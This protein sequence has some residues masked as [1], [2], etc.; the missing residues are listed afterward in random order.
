MALYY[1]GWALSRLQ[2]HS[3]ARESLVI[4]LAFAQRSDSD[5][6]SKKV[7]RR[8][9]KELYALPEPDDDDHADVSVVDLDEVV[10]SPGDPHR[11][12]WLLSLHEDA[13]RPWCVLPCPG[14]FAWLRCG[15]LAA[16][17]T[18]LACHLP[19]L[20]AMGLATRVCAEQIGAPR[21]PEEFCEDIVGQIARALA[22]GG[23]CLV[24]CSDGFAASGVVLACFL[25]VHGLDEPVGSG[26]PGKPQL[27]AGE[28]I[29]VLRAL[30]PGCLA[31]AED[32]EQ[33][34]AFAQAAWARHI[35]NAQRAFALQTTARS[36]PAQSA[37]AYPSDSA[38]SAPSSE[39][40]SKRP[41]PS[42]AR[43]VKQPGDGNCLFHSLAYGIGQTTAAT[44]RAAICSFMEKN[45]GLDIAGTPLAEWIQM[46]GGGN[47]A[48]YARKMAKGAEWGGA[49]EI[50]ACA[51]MSGINIH[52]YQRQG[53]G[54]ELTVP[55]D[56]GG[57]RTV[58]VLYVGGV[59]YDALVL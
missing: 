55:F 1:R 43:V 47:I 56:V 59:H 50:A 39:A 46:L 58:T 10:D 54:F 8:I 37:S 25:I 18:P 30:R 35:E 24:H 51:H 16:S 52:V 13:W 14:A 28:A 53:A 38:S 15:E 45:P 5:D 23:G 48:Q 42:S 27:T 41:A 33:I 36:R 31:Q 9:E 4:G 17:S 26:K 12:T 7:V 19:A 32:V 29:E 49:P 20:Q 3:D 6:A 57:S 21:D 22:E 11:A 44:L 40:K 2:R 34:H